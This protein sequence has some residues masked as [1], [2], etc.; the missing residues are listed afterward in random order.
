MR[1]VAL[2]LVAAFALHAGDRAALLERI[3]LTPVGHPV[4]VKLT[5]Q[6]ELRGRLIRA[7]AESIQVQVAGRDVLEE[8]DVP[9]R[10]IASFREL[11]ESEFGRGVRNGMGAAAGVLAVFVGLGLLLAAVSH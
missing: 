9:L 4:R 7:G 5:D 10:E 6:R 3:A 2:V 8:Q 1:I 11:R